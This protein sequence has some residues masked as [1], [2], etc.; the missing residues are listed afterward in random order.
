MWVTEFALTA[1]VALRSDDGVHHLLAARVL[2]MYFFISF[3]KA[4][5]I[6]SFVSIEWVV[7]RR[8]RALF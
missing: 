1:A 6:A 8:S 3:N 7:W 2:S 4:M 5:L